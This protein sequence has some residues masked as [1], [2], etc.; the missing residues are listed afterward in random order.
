VLKDLLPERLC[1]FLRDRRIDRRFP[2]TKASVHSDS[3]S[4]DSNLTLDRLTVS[5]L[6][7]SK[8]PVLLSPP[9]FLCNSSGASRNWT[10]ESSDGVTSFDSCVVYQLH[11]RYAPMVSSVHPTILEENLLPL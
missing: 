6:K 5:S 7:P 11:R 9:L 4:L 1:L 8:H 10:V 2:L 3:L